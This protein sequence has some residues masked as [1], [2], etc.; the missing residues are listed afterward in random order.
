MHSVK[1]LELR[2]LSGPLASCSE[3]HAGVGGEEERLGRAG[4]EEI[5]TG[6]H[7]WRQRETT[8]CT[9][10]GEVVRRERERR[11]SGRTRFL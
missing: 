5:G 11:C 2:A 1:R 9:V 4:E 7:S 3:I 10:G 8:R 6:S